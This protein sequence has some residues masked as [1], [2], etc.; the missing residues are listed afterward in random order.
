MFGSGLPVLAKNFPAL[1]ELVKNGKNG[2]LFDSSE[3]LMECLLE[4]ADDFPNNAVM[5]FIQTKKAK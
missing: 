2:I 3:D 4:I 5:K 1:P